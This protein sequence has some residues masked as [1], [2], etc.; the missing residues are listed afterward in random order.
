M[1][2]T[3]RLK[4]ADDLRQSMQDKKEV[5][6]VEMLEALTLILMKVLK[7]CQVQEEAI[8]ELQEKVKDLENRNAGFGINKSNPK[9]FINGWDTLSQ[10]NTI[11]RDVGF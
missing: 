2:N 11:T 10:G 1:T 8:L 9:N 5:N 6:L 3:E 7:V 4:E